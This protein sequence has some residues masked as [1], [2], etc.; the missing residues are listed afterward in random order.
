MHTFTL[1]NIQPA[2]LF[3]AILGLFSRYYQIQLLLLLKESQVLPPP[4]LNPQ[5]IRSLGVTPLPQYRKIMFLKQKML[6]Y[7]QFSSKY[8][9]LGAWIQEGNLKDQNDGLSDHQERVT[10]QSSNI[11]SQP[12]RPMTLLPQEVY[13]TWWIFTTAR[14]PFLTEEFQHHLTVI[15]V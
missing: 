1:R 11:G 6:T 10:S 13:L 9:N 4:F 8:L 5:W 15:T 7:Q 2:G 12:C 14:S 3:H